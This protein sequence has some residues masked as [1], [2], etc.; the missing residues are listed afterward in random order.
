MVAA[1]WSILYAFDKG[2]FINN[3][4]IVAKKNGLPF[5]KRNQ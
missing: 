4:L 5:K 1:E 2:G 3:Q